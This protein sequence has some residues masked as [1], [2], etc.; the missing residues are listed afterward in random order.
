MEIYEIAYELYK[1]DWV[2]KN[3]TE[4]VQL[5]TLRQYYELREKGD[6]LVSFDEWVS[7]VG[8]NGSLYAC[9]EEFCDVDYYDKHYMCEL[10]N[11]EYLIKLYYADPD[12]E[13]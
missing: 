5:Q 4:E 3:V 10:L 2:L 7:E 11:N 9:Y 8:Y 12:I 13:S 1:R 6:V